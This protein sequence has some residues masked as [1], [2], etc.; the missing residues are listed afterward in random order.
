MKHLLGDRPHD[1]RHPQD[2]GILARD[3]GNRVDIVALERLAD[4]VLVR[5]KQALD[6]RLVRLE[7]GG[8]LVAQIALAD[9]DDGRAASVR[10]LA[11]RRAR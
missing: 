2:D 4:L 5:L 6:A 7:R 10:R 11:H 8:D 1:Q 3:H 9:H